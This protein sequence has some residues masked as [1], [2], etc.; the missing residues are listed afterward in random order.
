MP[1]SFLYLSFTLLS[2]SIGKHVSCI[3][4]MFHEYFSQ[5]KL[6]SGRYIRVDKIFG[7]VKKWLLVVLDRWLFYEV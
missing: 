7:T 4:V 6:N 3:P 2:I 5:N 1:E